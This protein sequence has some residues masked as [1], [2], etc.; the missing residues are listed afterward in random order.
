MSWMLKNSEGKPDA[1]FTF[2]SVAFVVATVSVLLSF[3]NE[4]TILGFNAK[5]N[6]PNVGLMSIYL[7]STLLAYVNR[8]NT[9]LKVTKEGTTLEMAEMKDKKEDR[10][11]HG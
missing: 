5:I 10:V 7:G 4:I 3:F 11:L 2:A 9:K 8:R 6:E 1:M